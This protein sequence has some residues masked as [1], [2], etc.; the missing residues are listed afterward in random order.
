MKTLNI[1]DKVQV[2]FS[3]YDENGE[4]IETTIGDEPVEII[5]GSGISRFDDHLVGLEACPDCEYTFQ[6]KYDGKPSSDLIFRMERAELDPSIS[7]DEGKNIHFMA[8]TGQNFTAKIISVEKETV[9]LDAND[10]Y[11][12]KTVTFKISHIQP[13]TQPPK[14]ETNYAGKSPN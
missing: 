3:A 12:G 1:G 13:T 8:T 7:V 2:H 14:Q 9:L 11:L 4:L 10:P 5:V 6:E